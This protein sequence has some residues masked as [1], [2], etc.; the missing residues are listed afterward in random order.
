MIMVLGHG[1]NQTERPRKLILVWISSGGSKNVLKMD[2]YLFVWRG[3]GGLSHGI[4]SLS[5]SFVFC[6]FGEFFLLV[7]NAEL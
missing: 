3:G 5:F 4:S 7:F 2:H 6:F 1:A